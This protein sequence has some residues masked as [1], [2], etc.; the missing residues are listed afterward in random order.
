[1]AAAQDRPG[2]LSAYKLTGRVAL[3]TGAS[4]NLGLG[5]AKALAQAGADVAM[6]GRDPQTI[7]AAAAEIDSVGRVS[8]PVVGDVS[9]VDDH[10][11]I[12]SDV[13]DRFGRLDILVNNAGVNRP[14]SPAAI[15]PA[16]YDEIHA[17]N[18]RGPFFLAQ[19]AFPHLAASGHGSLINVLSVGMW[20]GGPE[21]LLYR[22]SK[23][24][25]YGVTMVLAQDW[26]R[27]GIRVNAIAPGMVGER[28]GGRA[29]DPDAERFAARTPLG[30]RG[31][32]EEVASAVLYLA[33]DASTFTTGRCSRSTVGP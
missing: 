10:E 16:D 21:L 17:A 15:T 24:A 29:L 9:A 31:T 12:L 3:V 18:A 20:T 11:Q 19:A 8:L 27:H 7:T 28:T 1:M 4:R 25:L 2:Q 33:S 6:V 26:A 5:M 22:S 13:I 23:L 30:R 14:K 32:V